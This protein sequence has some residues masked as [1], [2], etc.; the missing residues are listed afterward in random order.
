VD[1]KAER[2]QL[3]LAHKRDEI[4]SGIIAILVINKQSGQ[5]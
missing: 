3:N 2:D 5:C 1:T 4:R